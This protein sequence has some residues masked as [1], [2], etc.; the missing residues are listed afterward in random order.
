VLGLGLIG[1]GEAIDV[2]WLRTKPVA[3]RPWYRARVAPAA[4]CWPI[5]API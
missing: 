5:S 3:D 4:A 1:A 2:E